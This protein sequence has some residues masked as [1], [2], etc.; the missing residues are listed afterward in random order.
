MAVNNNWG[1]GGGGDGGNTLKDGMSI[2][3]V[4]YQ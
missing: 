3:E 4:G 1:R 2:S